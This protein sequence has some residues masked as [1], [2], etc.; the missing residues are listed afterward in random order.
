MG[1]SGECIFEPVAPLQSPRTG[2][3]IAAEACNGISSLIYSKEGSNIPSGFSVT[4]ISRRR[5]D[6]EACA[7]SP[8]T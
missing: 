5:T 8:L 2:G 4:Q 7:E 3:Q 6:S 1:K